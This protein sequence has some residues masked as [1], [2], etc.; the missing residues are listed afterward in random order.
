VSDI[1]AYA[2]G[3]HDVTGDGPPPPPPPLGPV[4]PT[5][6]RTAGEEARTLVAQTSVATLATLSDDGGP[7]ASLVSYAALQDGSPVLFVSTLAE[8]GR[9][10]DRDPRASLVVAETPSGN[11]PLANGRVTLAGRV[12]SPEGDQEAIARAAYLAA[13]PTARY[14]QSFGDFSLYVLQVERVRWVGGYG[15]MDSADADAYANAEADPVGK[16][17]GAVKHL[18]EDHADALL[19]MA[20]ALGGYPDAESA[21]CTGADR[22]GLDLTVDTP[23][24]TAPAR[25]GF[26]EPV[27]DPAGLRGATV[28]L[29]RRARATVPAAE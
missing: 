13:V 19:V 11:D 7:W 29:T 22:Y 12:V 4:P 5:R 28:E 17:D 15:R 16:P 2:T 27:T 6:R 25:V 24:G 18:N 20:Q 8:H 1:T 10:L 21:R 3:D 23:R 26:A 9:N 14:Y